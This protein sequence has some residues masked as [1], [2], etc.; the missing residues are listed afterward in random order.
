MKYK[1]GHFKTDAACQL[2]VSIAYSGKRLLSEIH[3]K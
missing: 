1:L 2:S 3:Y